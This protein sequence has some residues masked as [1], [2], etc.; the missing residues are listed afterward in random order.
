MFVQHIMYACTQASKDEE[1]KQDQESYNNT[2]DSVMIIEDE[3]RTFFEEKGLIAKVSDQPAVSTTDPGI[4]EV[5]KQMSIAQAEARQAQAQAQAEAKQ[6]QAAA[7]EHLA[8]AAAEAEERG[9][10]EAAEAREAQ[11]AA[12]EHQVNT[13]ADAE[14]RLNLVL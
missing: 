10:K 2:L 11:V 9:E 5:L 8:K 4:S 12:E 13:T 6:A 1:F 7:E 14:A 3:V